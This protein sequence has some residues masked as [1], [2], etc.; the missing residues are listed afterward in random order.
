VCF[1]LY[2]QMNSCIHKFLHGH[3]E[4]RG[5]ISRMCI[6]NASSSLFCDQI[7]AHFLVRNERAGLSRKTRRRL[8]QPILLECTLPTRHAEGHA[9]CPVEVHVACPARERRNDTPIV[10]C[11]AN[12]GPH[13]GKESSGIPGTLLFLLLISL[14]LSCIRPLP[15]G[16]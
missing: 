1:L 13:K 6:R 15:L 8:T 7:D 3:M 2:F 12:G 5:F 4:C 9:A 14:S 10:I 16:L 11:R